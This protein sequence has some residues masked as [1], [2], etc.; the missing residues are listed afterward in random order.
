MQTDILSLFGYF[1]SVIIA[2]S[3]TM[4]S[5]V[6]FRW[7]NM[8]GAFSFAIYGLL[9][10]AIPVTFLNG[11]IVAVDIYYLIK[12]YSKKE[13]FQILEISKDNKYLKEFLNFH[14]KDIEHFF[15]GFKYN[16]DMNTLSFFVLRNLN[17]AGAFLA[18]KEG[19][20]TLMVGLDYVIPQYRD[21]KNGKFI[22]SHLKKYFVKEGIKKVSAI[23]LNKKHI[24]YLEKLGF[25]KEGT[26]GVYSKTLDS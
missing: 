1:A 20:N 4:S 24:K 13:V 7:I 17:V 2:I 15:P 10:N 5:I 8:I 12:I 19:D 23:P 16:P 22:Y 25:V 21:L 9:I 6:K 11:F 3:M 26:S 18:H 14:K